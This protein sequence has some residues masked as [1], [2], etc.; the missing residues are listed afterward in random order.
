MKFIDN[1]MLIIVGEH[2]QSFSRWGVRRRIKVKLLGGVRVC[3]GSWSHSWSPDES[4]RH[5]CDGDRVHTLASLL[6][7]LADGAFGCPQLSLYLTRKPRRDV[8]MRKNV[9]FAQ[10]FFWWIFTTIGVHSKR[11]RALPKYSVGHFLVIPNTQFDH[12]L[13]TGFN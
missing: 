7:R 1:T 5:W 8:D 4:S 13:N 3:W 2:N 12:Y 6:H 9:F 11:I 10:I